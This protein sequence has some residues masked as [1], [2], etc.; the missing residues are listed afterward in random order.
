MHEY[1]DSLSFGVGK[2]CLQISIDRHNEGIIYL[3]P[4]DLKKE[5]C[6]FFTNIN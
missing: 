2:L 4:P 5:I 3:E 1:V 6:R